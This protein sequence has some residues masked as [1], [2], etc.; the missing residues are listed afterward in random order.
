MSFSQRA[1]ELIMY[2]LNKSVL[3]INV[4]L[5]Q[6]RDYS[7]YLLRIGLDP[8]DVSPSRVSS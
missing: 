5:A 7:L 3:H 8:L 1:D 6:D 4:L 2:E